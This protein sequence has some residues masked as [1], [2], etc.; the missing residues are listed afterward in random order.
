MEQIALD[1]SNKHIKDF[2]LAIEYKYLMK[3]APAGVYL[4]PEYF[5]IRFMIM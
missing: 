5:N 1:K 3:Q 2:K 4:L